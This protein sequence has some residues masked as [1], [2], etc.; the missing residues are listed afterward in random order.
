[1]ENKQ[2]RMNHLVTKLNE[3]RRTYEQE[4][5]SIM[6]DFEYD[7]LYDE[8]VQLEKELGVTLSTSPTIN[9]GYQ[10]VSE[11]PKEQH[12]KPMLSL[13]KTKDVSALMDFLGGREGVI[14]WKLDGLT[15][16]L[17]YKD[18]QL[19]KGVTRGNGEVGEVITNNVR[20]FKNVPLQIPFLGELIVRGEAI[21]SYS[22]FN[23][24]NQQIEDV[25][26]KYKNPRNL[27]SGSVR[28]LNSEITAKRNV[29]FLGFAIIKSDNLGD[30]FEGLNV[31]VKDTQRDTV[32]Q[33]HK[34]ILRNVG[35]QGEHEELQASLGNSR[36]LQLDWL[37]AQGFQVVEH[38]LLTRDN[39][40]EVVADFSSR[41]ADFDLPTDG[42]VLT[43]DDISYGESL[44]S[45]SKF[46]RDS[47]AFKWADELKETTLKEIE[48]NASRTGLINPVAIFDAVE[49]EGSS[50]SRA[51]VHN[52]SI[53]EE[54]KLGIGDKIE[55]YK[56]NMI[57]P[58]I[59]NNLTGSGNITP[60]EHCPVCGA[61]TIIAMDM[62]SKTLRCPNPHCQA[63]A[64]KT[65]NLFVSRDALN[66]EG[67]SEATI[68]KFVEKGFIK[69]I[70][71]FFELS[72]FKDEIV[73]MEGFGEKSYHNLI[74][75][76]EKAKHTTLPKLI[77]GLGINHV[78]LATAKEIC[79]AVHYDFVELMAMTYEDLVDIDGVGSV[80]AKSVTDYFADEHNR[81]NFTR[82]LEK[83]EIFR[84][85][86]E[87]EQTFA[88]KTFVITGN[89]HH[90]ANRNEIKEIIENR[91]GKVSGSVSAKTDYLINN[92]ITS[93][94][95]KNKKARE[96]GIPIISEEA[97]L[98][99]LN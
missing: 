11:L 94:S 33:E 50:V 13:D 75:S 81:T 77:Y 88:G 91:G 19:I 46:P 70:P 73:E 57:I 3:A 25:D 14:S 26:A 20:T 12:E 92:E 68:E 4:S 90:F 8:L 74:S 28:Q 22:D 45:T 96:L 18:G 38:Y 59:A 39:V 48:W 85:S 72:R 56:A 60:P 55:V 15:V 44:G 2:H 89:V 53:M 52:L 40:E 35:E 1:M 80:I 34:Y 79:K 71:D 29:H 47:L 64:V 87:S 61:D 84:E 6:S 36:K 99:M 76:L 41:V 42:L 7:R 67:L 95:S 51:S 69:E 78:G 31:S 86:L 30:D 17:T 23:R 66:I 43:Y 54:L 98:Q 16:V 93:S 82:L 10:I 9:V 62:G 27:C 5:H 49:L 32:T 24:L 37:E 58:Q 21:I 97:F 65:Y 63:K 83:V